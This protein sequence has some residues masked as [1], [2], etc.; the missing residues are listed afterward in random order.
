[1]EMAFLVTLI[2]LLLIAAVFDVSRYIIPNVV[3]AVLIV[4]FV[5]AAVLL[6]QGQP[7]WSYP[8]AA[9]IVFGIG[10]V[11][12]AFRIMGAGDIK[13]LTAVSLWAGLAELPDFLVMVAVSGGVIALLLI[14]LRRVLFYGMVSIGTSENVRLPKILVTG[15]PVPYGVA[16]A[17]GGIWL[18]LTLPYLGGIA[19]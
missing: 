7:W 10:V 3:S 19:R 8:A 14:V 1:M 18:A 6:P 9:L 5:A 2:A 11:G 17:T 13:L 4:A 12:Y 15:A 16:I